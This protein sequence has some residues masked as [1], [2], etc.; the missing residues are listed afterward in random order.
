MQSDPENDLISPLFSN[1]NDAVVGSYDQTKLSDAGWH[2]CAESFDQK[3]VTEIDNED[4]WMYIRRFNKV[5]AFLS[6]LIHLGEGV[7][8]RATWSC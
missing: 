2:Q 7:V 8:D 6:N 3:L 4:V 5:R 1:S